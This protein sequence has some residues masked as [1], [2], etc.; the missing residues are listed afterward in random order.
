MRLKLK[1]IIIL[2]TIMLLCRGASFVFSEESKDVPHYKRPNAYAHKGKEHVL[3]ESFQNV[4][5]EKQKKYQEQQKIKSKKV[6]PKFAD[7][8]KDLWRAEEISLEDF[9]KSAYPSFPTDDDPTPPTP[10]GNVVA[11]NESMHIVLTSW[12]A[13]EDPESG[14]EWYA[15]GVGTEPGLADI[16]YW[17]AVY[18]CRTKAYFYPLEYELE[19][20]DIVYVSVYAINGENMNSEII[21]SNPVSLAYEELGHQANN[22]GVDYADYG[23]DNT[24]LTI[25]EGW[26]QDQVDRF[27]YFTSRMIPIIKE[28]YGSSARDFAV[29]FVRDLYYSY[30]NMYFPSYNEIHMGDAWYPQL[31][32]HELVHVFRDNVLIT[33]NQ[34]WQYD[35]TLS[36]FEEG[37]AQ[38]VS[39]ECMNKYIEMYP[40]DPYVNTNQIWLSDY[41]WDYDFQNVKEL[42]TTDFWS[43]SGG[44]GIFWERYEMAAAAIRKIQIEKQEDNFYSDF[45]NKWYALLNANHDL[46]SSRELV[47][48]IIKEIIP[49]IEGLDATDWINQQY[50]FDCQIHP[51]RKIWVRTQ[52]YPCWQNYHINQWIKCY[53]TFFNG[54]DWNYWN[55]YQWVYHYLNGSEGEAILYDFDNNRVWGGDLLIE[56]TENPPVW[57]GFGLDEKN[58]ITID[59]M[60][61]ETYVGGLHEL[62]LYKM[63]VTFDNF[64]N[65]P[66]VNDMEPIETTVYRVVGDELVDFHGVWGGIIGDQGGVIYINHED[67][68]KE[69]AMPVINGAFYGE[70]S[71]AGV[72]NSTT[73]YYDTVPGKLQIKYVDQFGNLYEKKVNID[74]GSWNG[75]HIFLF[76]FASMKSMHASTQ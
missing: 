44:M 27:E 51:G 57:Y 14:I 37:F 49:T 9:D 46:R 71:W 31:L 60:P 5:T 26:N 18:P 28:V 62:N 69:E 67:F 23:L 45:N 54:S 34:L 33:S 50:I 76:D 8:T 16:R 53:E 72:F 41:E 70:R 32:T 56:P 38:A 43:D 47:V 7:K 12:D 25:I 66:A 4:L 15:F 64:E 68:P 48:K 75:N 36:G 42:R 30:S 19:E 3:P 61:P 74:R 63:D 24:G 22:V 17:Q 58:L 39:Y 20:G 1:K 59:S 73:G 6:I 40:G 11:T 52:H 35:N 13:S 55:G 21:A 10:P 2:V 65:T 29:T